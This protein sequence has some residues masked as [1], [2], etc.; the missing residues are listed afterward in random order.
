[1]LSL[2]VCFQNGTLGP[3][4]MPEP[5]HVGATI[6]RDL[7]PPVQNEIRQ[8]VE[9]TIERHLKHGLSAANQDDGGED[10]KEQSD[11]TQMTVSVSF[12]LFRSVDR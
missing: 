8:V 2:L 6:F 5:E 11:T 9:K 10:G 4:D 1:M 12:C 3:G 7:P